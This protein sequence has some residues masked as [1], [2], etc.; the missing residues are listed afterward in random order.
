MKYLNLAL[1]IIYALEIRISLIT[2]K[3]IQLVLYLKYFLSLRVLGVNSC[4]Q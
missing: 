2:L 1:Y 3:S 4:V